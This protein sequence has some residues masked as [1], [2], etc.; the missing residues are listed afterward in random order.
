MSGVSM[1]VV[2]VVEGAVFV[3]CTVLCV[4]AAVAYGTVAVGE[5]RRIVPRAHRRHWLTPSAAA[6]VDIGCLKLGLIA[7]EFAA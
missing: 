6:M 3:V 4:G 2:V 7:A 1:G 5:N